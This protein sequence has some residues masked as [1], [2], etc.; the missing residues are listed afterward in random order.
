MEGNK[1]DAILFHQLVEALLKCLAIVQLLVKV[2][3][4]E[5]LQGA[6]DGGVGFTGTGWSKQDLVK[7][8]Y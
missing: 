7:R 5:H 3:R 6:V 2:C 4:V 8:R 1:T